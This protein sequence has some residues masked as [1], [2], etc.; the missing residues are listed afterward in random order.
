MYKKSIL[1]IAIA[2]SLMLTGCFENNKLD[3]ENDGAQTTPPVTET[4]GSAY[5]AFN[6]AVSD[7]PIPNDLIFDSVAGDGTFLV[8]DSSPVTSA[9]NQISG[10]STIAPIDV[11][12][13]SGEIDVDTLAGNVYLLELAYAS[14]SPVQGLSIGEPPTVAGLANVALEHLVLDGNSYIRINPKTPLKP[15]TRYEVVITNGVKD[16]L[17]QPLVRNPGVASYAA[18]SDPNIPLANPALAP[19]QTLIN[20]LWEPTALA[21]F[22]LAVN[23]VREANNLEPLGDSNIVLSYTLTTSG[24]E[25]VLNYIADPA[26]WFNDQLTT[27]I[28][29]NTAKAVIAGGSPSHASITAA[30]TAQIDAFPSAGIAAA[31]G[32]FGSGAPCEGLTG[33]TAISCTGSVLGSPVGP[34]G[35]LLP[36]PAATTVTFDD[37]SALDINLVS[38][39]TGSLG[40]PAGLVS[41]VQGE[42]TI[43]YYAGVPSGSNGTPLITESWEAD[44]TLAS[45]INTAFAPLGLQIPQADPLVSNVVN[46][47]FPFPKK[48]DDVT[49]PVLGIHP[50]NPAGTMSTVMYQ[51]GITTDR[52]A[53]LAFGAN[54]VA[55]AKGQGADIGIIAIDQPLHGI[56]GISAAE[57]SGLATQLLAGAMLIDP[58]DGLD[59]TENG[60]IAAAVNGTLPIGVL[61]ASQ[62]GG[63]PSLAGLDLTG[64][65]PADIGTALA[66]VTTGNCGPTAQAQLAGAQTLVRTVANGASTIPGLNRITGVDERHFGFT[67]AGAGVAPNAMDYT[68][69]SAANSSGS[70]FINLTSFLTSRDNLRQQVLDLL[71]VRKSL[72]TIDV[73][74]ASA[75]GDMSDS[76]V[77]FIGHSLGTINGLPF[78]AVA[79]NST[80]TTD[81]I[82]AANML[83]PGS[84]I[85]RLLEN[86]PS[87]SVPILAGLASLGLTQDTSNFQAY[88]NVLQATLDSGDP[89]NFVQD[90]GPGNQ[91]TAVLFT[92]VVDDATIPNS[93]DS[94]TEVLGNGSIAYMSGSEPLVDLLSATQLTT[95][96]TSALGQLSVRY[97]SEDGKVTHGTPVL[98][99]SRTAE[100]I[101]AFTEM[102]SQATSMVLTGGTNIIVTND[103]VLEGALVP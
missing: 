27:F 42:M 7:L 77:Y 93:L 6:P 80:T 52:S 102:V 15:L 73:N 9:L 71:A 74:G 56:D 68:G 49:I 90:L 64:A 23:P 14:G 60:T 34:F 96:G 10:A 3:D 31:L 40:I 46:Y 75:N 35:A 76:D 85:T 1:S 84:G 37:A 100:E 79:N 70:L 21:F 33:A 83:T 8:P 81:D 41:V 18:L 86:S 30:V 101:A 11:K 61:V 32:L 38:S 28:G 78:L 50:T 82:T 20:S 63:C 92:L 43:P 69:S 89:A 99:S 13:L 25:K 67:S 17:G 57:Q 72:G 91:N 59:A 36:T 55:G 4:S 95:A 2:S 97:K 26:Q 19:V 45:A 44:D 54:M 47:I 5:P 98:P 29:V 39:L 22:N 12:I 94:D 16:T 24:D 87:F 48:K 62:D 53:A 51:H 65:V 58:S 88:M 103:D 66:E